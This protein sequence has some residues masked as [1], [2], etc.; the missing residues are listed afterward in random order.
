VKEIRLACTHQSPDWREYK[1]DVRQPHRELEPPRQE[2][3]R[4]DA[5][6]AALAEAGILAHTRY[7]AG[8][9]GE[10]RAAVAAAFDI[11][12]TAI[13]PRTQRLLYA[14]NAI[15]EPATMVAVGV[16]CGFTF[17]ANAGAGAG[18]GACY[19]AQRLIGI[20]IDAKEAGRAARNVAAVDP[21]GRARIVAAD[22][23]EYLR[24]MA[25]TIDLL[26]LDA[27]A[28]DARGKSIYLDLLDAARHALVRGSLVLAHNSVNAAP[29]LADYLE[30]VRTPGDFGASVNVCLDG[31][32]LEVS[33]CAA[34][35]DKDRAQGE[36]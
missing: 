7:D 22:G 24:D 12:W 21:A 3:E 32:G 25:G 33:I 16:F 35:P 28:G 9:F 34:G 23:V 31:E 17:M 10:Y 19:A 8:L 18:P 13:T 36:R 14:I 15:R 30:A 11:P 5:A 27:N 2:I 6:L 29:A 26:Y 20:E 1:M 4:V